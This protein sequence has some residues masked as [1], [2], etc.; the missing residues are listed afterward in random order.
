VDGDAL[1]LVPCRMNISTIYSRRHQL[2]SPSILD[3]SKSVVHVATKNC[4]DPKC[5]QTLIFAI[6]G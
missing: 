4:F 5:K 6:D 3:L 1:Y 2:S